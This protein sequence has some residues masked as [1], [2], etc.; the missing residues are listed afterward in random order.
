MKELLRLAAF[1]A[2]AIFGLAGCASYVLAP[3]TRAKLESSTALE[4]QIYKDLADDA[5]VPRKV[6]RAEA[7]GLYCSD[8]SILAGD[9]HAPDGGLSCP[10]VPK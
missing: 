8:E 9:G 5:S 1:R 7:R 4:G 10:R 3:A 6:L 2:A